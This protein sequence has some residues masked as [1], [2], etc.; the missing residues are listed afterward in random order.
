MKYSACIEMLFADTPFIKRIYRAKKAG[1]HAVEFWLWQN[2]D[3]DAIKKAL[4]DT[5][6]QIGVF[7]GNISGRMT[8]PK[9]KNLYLDGVMLSVQTAKALNAHHLF[10]MSDILK[11]DRTVKEPP[12]KISPEKKRAA[13]M[14]ILKELAPVGKKEGITFVIEPLNVM[15][16]HKG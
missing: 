13:T 10:L 14:A 15:G 8:D 2:K 16:D 9:D 4:K 12:Y 1:F 11:A 3:I 5:G 7:Q 6:L